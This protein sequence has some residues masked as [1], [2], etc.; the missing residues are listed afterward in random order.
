MFF[1]QK[2]N[3]DG[4]FFQTCYDFV[5]YWPKIS[6]FKGSNTPEADL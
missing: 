4:G 1:S 3:P 6:D 5:L 2:S